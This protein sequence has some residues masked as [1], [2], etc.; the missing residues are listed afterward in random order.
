MSPPKLRGNSSV[1]SGK[2]TMSAMHENATPREPR[3]QTASGGFLKKILSGRADLKNDAPLKALVILAVPSIGLFFLNT[4]LGL[5]DAIFVSWLG[6][7]PMAAMSFTGPVNLCIFATLE[8]V[9][10]GAAS[11][12]GRHL[13][14]SDLR[15]ARHIARSALAL[16]YLICLLSTPMIHPSV[17]N[18][19]FRLIGTGGNA[20][21]LRLCWLY[22]LWIPIMLPFIGYT[23]I[24]N[25]VMRAQGDTLTPF[26][27]I[28][29]A[30][31]INLILDPIFIFTFDWGIS[32]AAIATLVSR[33]AASYYLLKRMPRISAI[34]LHPLLSPRT[35]L[36]AWWGNILRIGFPVALSTAS[37]ALGMGSVNS[38]LM[39]YGHRA[40]SAW[41]LGMR[42]EDVAFNFLMG[43]NIALIPFVSFNY[44]RG[45]LKRMLAGMRAAIYLGLGLMCSIGVLLYIRPDLVL[46]LF[47]PTREIEVMAIQAIRASIP[48]YPF[49]V[50]LVLAG[51][52][53][54]GVG[55]S[56]YGTISQ[57][58][59]SIV[60]RISAAWLFFQWLPQEHIWWFQSLAAVLGALAS[61]VFFAIVLKGLRRTMGPGPEPQS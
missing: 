40:V 27:A 31:L 32:G 44:G 36:T 35:E 1:S 50:F 42:V 52:F 58:L 2:G 13:G 45:D 18:S 46:A 53:F 8:C 3:L 48:S 51:G 39:G 7:L 11:L 59:R 6:E 43:L 34:P 54:V 29:L 60:F 61:A 23:Y 5:A 17:S 56:I 25:T 30:N 9:G 16:L 14:R 49:T 19:V 22:N 37:V 24:A 21:L 12:I 28:A 38:I 57:I 4:L 41:M 47:R 55:Q 15:G 20:E 33:L 26:K 10:G